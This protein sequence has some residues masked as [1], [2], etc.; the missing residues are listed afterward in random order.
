MEKTYNAGAAIGIMGGALGSVI[1]LFITGLATNSPFYAFVPTIC[2][3]AGG[4]FALFLLTRRPE[5]RQIIAGGVILWLVAIN[6][7][8]GNLLFD[9]IPSAVWGMSTGK[10]TFSRLHLNLLLVAMSLFGIYL[11]AQGWR[12]KPE[13]RPLDVVP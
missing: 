9:R 2:G 8:F 11:M 6:F 3:L 4:F 12:K 1:W 13:S 10:A 5:R 7:V